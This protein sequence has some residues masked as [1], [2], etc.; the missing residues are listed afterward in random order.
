MKKEDTRSK[1]DSGLSQS[2]LPIIENKKAMPLEM[3]AKNPYQPEPRKEE[4]RKI[5]I[6]N[7][8]LTSDHPIS[9]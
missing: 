3:S 1:N 9:P 4:R 2:L 7:S 5:V 8:N 6:D